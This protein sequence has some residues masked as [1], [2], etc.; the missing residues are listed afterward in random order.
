MAKVNQTKLVGDAIFVDDMELAKLNRLV[1]DTSQHTPRVRLSFTI[2]EGV[3][4]D[5]KEV[6]LIG[7]IYTQG[8]GVRV[9]GEDRI[10]RIPFE[11]KLKLNVGLSTG[12]SFHIEGSYG[13]KKV[14]A[15]ELSNAADILKLISGVK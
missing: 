5:A 2:S 13:A 11:I 9:V 10:N 14:P 4:S 6:D 8:M 12:I 15:T 3:I 7:A 1:I